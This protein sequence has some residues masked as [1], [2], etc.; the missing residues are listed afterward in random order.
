MQFANHIPFEAFQWLFVAIVFYVVGA[1]SYLNYRKAKN[2]VS[3]SVALSTS[4]AGLSYLL[5]AMPSLFTN[6]A[7]IIRYAGVAGDVNMAFVVGSLA[8]LL[9][10]LLLKGKKL[11]KWLFFIPVFVISLISSIITIVE[12]KNFDNFAHSL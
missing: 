11:S 6:N 12:A 10:L 5:W 7:D 3:L 8:V 2:P 4:G 9:W 1:R